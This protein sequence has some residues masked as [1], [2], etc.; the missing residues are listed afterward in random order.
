MSSQGEANG[1]SPGA[2][3][4]PEMPARLSAWFWRGRTSCPTPTRHDRSAHPSQRLQKVFAPFLPHLPAVGRA[5]GT[6]LGGQ[7]IWMPRFPVP[8]AMCSSQQQVFALRTPTATLP[9]PK[10]HLTA[11]SPE[12]G[13]LDN[14]YTSTATGTSSGTRKSGKGKQSH[15]LRAALVSAPCHM[16]VPGMG[17]T[18]AELSERTCRLL[19]SSQDHKSSSKLPRRQADPASPGW[20]IPTT[21]PFLILLDVPEKTALYL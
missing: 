13:F 19:S 15:W 3:W 1:T 20:G 4:G 6:G 5:G 16:P 11:S 8:R 14:I 2:V 18:K 12:R 10:R 7:G 9:I 21:P 17:Q